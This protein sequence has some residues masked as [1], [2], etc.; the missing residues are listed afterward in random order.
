MIF[1]DRNAALTQD[2]VNRI[3]EKAVELKVLKGKYR[4]I[5]HFLLLHCSMTCISD[6]VDLHTDIPK[7]N[8][9]MD[10]NDGFV[11]TRVLVAMDFLSSFSKKDPHLGHGGGGPGVYVT[12]LI[13]HSDSFKKKKKKVSGSM[14]YKSFCKEQGIEVRATKFLDIVADSP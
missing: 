13:G 4:D 3:G 11:E 6:T 9:F 14:D 8:I 10:G 5:W 12:A 1:V 7:K 2:L